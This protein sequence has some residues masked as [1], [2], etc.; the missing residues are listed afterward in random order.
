MSED[1]LRLLITLDD[2]GDGPEVDI[3]HHH[4]EVTV[5]RCCSHLFEVN[6]VTPKTP[7][8][9]EECLKI[10]DP[11][12]HLRLCVIC[13]HVGCCNASK[14]KHA[15]KH[16]HSTNHPLMKSFEPAEEWGWCYADEIYFESFPGSFTT[17][18][19][20]NALAYE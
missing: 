9:C 15:I 16:F 8:G 11:W 6:N 18:W 17:Q 4:E 13:G 3:F 5:M 20:G 14:N 19:C 10:G 2:P 7:D 1:D 12:L